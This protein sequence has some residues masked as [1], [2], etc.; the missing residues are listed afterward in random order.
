MGSRG[1]GG[2]GGG[3]G[4]GGGCRSLVQ[5]ETI[6]QKMLNTVEEQN[7]RSPGGKKKAAEL[8]ILPP[9]SDDSLYYTLVKIMQIVSNLWMIALFSCDILIPNY[10]CTVSITQKILLCWRNVN[11]IIGKLSKANRSVSTSHSVHSAV[12]WPSILVTAV[13]YSDSK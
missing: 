3:G 10:F 1:G 11:R 7:S 4:V 2:G 5:V 12:L 6:T 13:S 8:I 9:S